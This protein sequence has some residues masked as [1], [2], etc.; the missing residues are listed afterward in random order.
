[1]TWNIHCKVDLGEVVLTFLIAHFS[2]GLPLVDII[3]VHENLRKIVKK[4]AQ[5]LS[6]IF[7]KKLDSMEKLIHAMNKLPK[8]VFSVDDPIHKNKEAFTK[9]LLSEDEERFKLTSYSRLV[10]GIGQEHQDVFTRDPNFCN[11]SCYLE[12]E[13]KLLMR[14][15]NI[16]KEFESLYAKKCQFN[17]DDL[18]YFIRRLETLG[19][20]FYDDDE[21]EEMD[22]EC[23][24]SYLNHCEADQC[25][26]PLAF[27][28]KYNPKPSSGHIIKGIQYATNTDFD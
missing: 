23:V 26:E 2:T 14:N 17:N 4:E 20:V 7:R 11:Y 6:K 25:L 24:I 5:P 15:A 22:A 10:Y 28:R 8:S 3:R 12:K 19:G 18:F 21:F 13:N 16:F 1:M 27:H 9:C